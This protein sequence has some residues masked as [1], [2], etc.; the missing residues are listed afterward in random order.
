MMI[1][2]TGKEDLEQ[3]CPT[4]SQFATCGDMSFECGDKQFFRIVF[5]L[6]NNQYFSQL[7]TKV[8]TGKALLPNLSPQMW[9]QGELG[10]TPLI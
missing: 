2:D 5:L 6:I 1:S 9:R 3:R 10:R 7:I 8:A 4:L